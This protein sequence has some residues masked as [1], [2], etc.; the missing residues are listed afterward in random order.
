[1]LPSFKFHHIGYV[2]NDI[3]STAALYGI[4]GYTISE[5]I[6]DGLQKVN[7]CFLTK[8]GAPSIELVEPL[9]EL[10][11]VNK[12]LKKSGVAPYHVCYEVDDIFEAYDALCE[13]G[14]IPLFR[15]VEAI[16]FNNKL[17]CYFFKKE[18]GYLELLN[19]I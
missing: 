19:V 5:I 14:Y 18:V 13:L 6:T 11:S 9:D 12:I 15:P 8:N 2:T 17:I 10:S 3:E 16:A 4:G 1:M 7:I